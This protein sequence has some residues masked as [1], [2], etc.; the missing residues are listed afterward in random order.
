[1]TYGMIQGMS[2]DQ[3]VFGSQTTSLP[4]AFPVAYRE[5]S[6]Y[7]WLPASYCLSSELSIV[8]YSRIQRCLRVQLKME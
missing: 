6:N 2:K 3:S 7:K 1:M 5:I 8:D 4:T